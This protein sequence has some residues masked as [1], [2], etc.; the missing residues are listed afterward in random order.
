M[1]LDTLI[2]ILAVAGAIVGCRNSKY[3]TPFTML[4]YIKCSDGGI[5]EFPPQPPQNLKKLGGLS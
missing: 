1:E 3:E 2:I 5:S 4:E